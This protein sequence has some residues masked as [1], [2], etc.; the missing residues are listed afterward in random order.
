MTRQGRSSA[1]SLPSSWTTW[2]TGC[3]PSATWSAPSTA[4]VRS[5]EVT[6]RWHDP[7]GRAR[8]PRRARRT[9]DPRVRP[10]GTHRPVDAAGLSAHRDRRGPPATRL[11]TTRAEYSTLADA[12]RPAHLV[13]RLAGGQPARTAGKGLIHRCAHGMK[14]IAQDIYGS[15]DDVL[16]LRDIGIPVITGIP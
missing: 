3:A 6:R 2:R 5:T 1:T 15:P 16:E 14:A 8:G 12:L 4:P 9:D 13:Q 10:P 11:R 7:G